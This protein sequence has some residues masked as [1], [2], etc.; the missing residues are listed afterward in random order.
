MV[1]KTTA[2]GNAIAR[3]PITA[4]S[5]RKGT[6]VDSETTFPEN[7]VA[8]VSIDAGMSTASKPVARGTTRARVTA[9]ARGA[10]A[11]A[12]PSSR[13]SVASVFILT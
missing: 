9:T 11:L 4:V 7:V 6:T 1:A 2:Q 10:N 3:K 8:L 12:A 5:S 13:A